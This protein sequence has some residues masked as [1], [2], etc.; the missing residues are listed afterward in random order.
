MVGGLALAASV[1]ACLEAPPGSSQ[2]PPPAD[3]SDPGDGATGQC[4]SP[5]TNCEADGTCVI[6]CGEEECVAGVTCPPG[7]PCHVT[8]E[9]DTAC[10]EVLVDCSAATACEI[11]CLGRDACQSGVRCGGTACIIECNGTDACADGAIR[12]DAEDCDISCDGSGACG[13]V[14]CHD[15]SCGLECDSINEVGCVCAPPEATTRFGIAA[16]AP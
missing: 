13:N 4:P 15:Q 11:E 10:E 1:M 2:P 9:G 8:C 6:H 12:C 16:A 5:C 14:C 3:A 7:R